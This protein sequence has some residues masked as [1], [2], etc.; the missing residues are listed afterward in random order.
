MSGSL[1]KLTIH[2][3][4]DK[5]FKQKVADPY[6]KFQVPVNPELF[7]KSYKVELDTRAPHGSSGVNPNFKAIGPQDFKVE[8]LFDGTN[9]IEGYV[10]NKGKKGE[11]VS[12][13]NQLDNFMK[14][15][16]EY[17]GEIHKPHYLVVFWGSE[18]EFA[19]VL[20]N[21]EVNYTLFDPTGFPIRVKINAT[22]MSYATDKKLL[23]KARLQSPDLTHYQKVQQGDRL[24]SMTYA[25][26]N[27]PKYFQK[28]AYT[29]NLSSTRNVKVGFNMKFPPLDQLDPNA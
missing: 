4:L 2:A 15:V 13:H 22:F 29:N 20:S 28:V 7:T 21:L 25:I 16:Y 14:C 11:D 18:I 17:D 23:A 24:D 6:F 26:Y 27:D 1:T 19:C 9:T 10:G 5:E 12:V 3:Y 8:F